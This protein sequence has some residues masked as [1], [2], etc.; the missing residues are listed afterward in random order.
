MTLFRLFIV[1]FIISIVAFLIFLVVYLTGIF[2]VMRMTELNNVMPHYP[3]RVFSQIFSPVF[4]ISLAVT[5]LSGLV[6]R[7]IGIVLVARNDKLQGGEQALWIIGLIL[8]GFI[9]AIVFMAIGKSR[10]LIPATENTV[11]K[12]A[13]L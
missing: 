6:Y 11:L 9:T 8:F 13:G 12:D 2:N 4:F 1:S 10:N 3:F 5:F 7:V